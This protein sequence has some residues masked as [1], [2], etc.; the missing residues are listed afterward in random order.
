RALRARFLAQARDFLEQA[1]R[2]DPAYFPAEVNLLCVLTLQGNF[3][4]AKKFC[5]QRRLLQR[6]GLASAEKNKARLALAIVLAQS[7]DA[8]EQ[9]QAEQIFTDLAA[10]GAPVFLAKMASHNL[11]V[12]RENPA[13]LAPVPD[14][15]DC[16]QPAA[17]EPSDKIDGVFIHRDWGQPSMA[18]PGEAGF[19]LFLEKR[20]GSRLAQFSKSDQRVFSLQRMAK[21]KSAAAVRFPASSRPKLVQTTAGAFLICREEHWIC[22]LD[23][24]GRVLEW[25]KFYDFSEK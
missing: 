25:G 4:E 1:L 6:E 2:L 19:F 21:V 18:L 15:G 11:E 22:L 10:P 5:E 20:P 17:F 14:L 12:L 9:A 23:E 24:R 16:I 8:G 3:S 7:E 13:V